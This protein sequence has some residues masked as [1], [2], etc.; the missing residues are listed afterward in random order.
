M[1]SLSA[2]AQEFIPLNY[3]YAG[4]SLKHQIQDRQQSSLNRVVNGV[5]NDSN[6]SLLGAYMPDNAGFSNSQPLQAISTPQATTLIQHSVFSSVVHPP[7]LSNNNKATLQYSS[8]IT[9]PFQFNYDL[10]YNQPLS[11]P[12]AAPA[13]HMPQQLIAQAL[14]AATYQSQIK[15]YKILKISFFFLFHFVYFALFIF[16]YSIAICIRQRVRHLSCHQ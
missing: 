7:H 14:T 11:T 9:Q 12:I 5:F 13:T 4:D 2:N 16:S 15:Y 8:P 6:G 3:V 10:M 1:K